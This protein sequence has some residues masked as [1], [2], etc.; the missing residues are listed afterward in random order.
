MHL[1]LIIDE[2]QNI[3]ISDIFK[4]HIILMNLNFYLEF[5]EILMKVIY[6]KLWNLSLIWMSSDDGQL[7]NM[8][9]MSD[10]FD[11]FRKCCYSSHAPTRLCY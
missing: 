6:R 11:I 1:R 5:L 7:E 2:K 10:V 4:F 8:L 3:I 9:S